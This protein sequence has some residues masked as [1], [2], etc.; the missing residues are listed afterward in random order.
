MRV[1]A[2]EVIPAMVSEAIRIHL[3]VERDMAT[4]LGWA[5]G[6]EGQSQFEAGI[7]S[8]LGPFCDK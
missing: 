7:R 2:L 5:S 8:R 6:D 1:Q 4:P 3:V